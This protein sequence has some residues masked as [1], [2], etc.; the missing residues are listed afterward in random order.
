MIVRVYTAILLILLYPLSAY[1]Q[2]DSRWVKKLVGRWCDSSGYCRPDYRWHRAAPRVY[3]AR[4]YDLGHTNPYRQGNCYPVRATVGIE[5]YN[6]EEARSSAVELWM[7][8]EKLHHGVK[9]MSPEHAIVFSDGGK[10][11][12]CYPSSTGTRA[13]ERAAETI[14]KRLWQCEFIARPCEPQAAPRRW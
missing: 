8:A 4:P 13:S 11:P 14:G 2:E 10:G 3:H 7:E 9:Y 5:K 6:V 12:D 1:G